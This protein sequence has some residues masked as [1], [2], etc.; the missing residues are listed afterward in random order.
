MIL[1]AGSCTI[2]LE[3]TVLDLSGMEPVV[4]RPG[5]VT[6]EEV[7][8]VLGCVVP[9]DLGNHEQPKSPGQ[10]LKHYAPSIPLRMNAVDLEKGEALLAFGP[11]KFMGIKGGGAAKD[12]PDHAIRNLSE[13]GDLHEAAANL[14]RMLR[15]LD[16]PEN[17][18]IAVMSIPDRGVGRA[19]NDR[20][21]RATR[22]Y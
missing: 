13:T 12:L 2:G 1:A 10:L 4:L 5:A 11:V 17:K 15:E 3:S 21:Q 8:E 6:A 22:K 14:F 7:S 19:I 20:L 9:Y 16:M 18:K